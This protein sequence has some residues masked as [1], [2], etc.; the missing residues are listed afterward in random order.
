MR[1]RTISSSISLYFDANAQCSSFDLVKYWPQVEMKNGGGFSIFSDQLARRIFSC[2]LAST[3][4]YRLTTIL[5]A[6]F[7]ALHCGCNHSSHG[8]LKAY[9]DT[10]SGGLSFAFNFRPSGH[11]ASRHRL[12][13]WV[14]DSQ[15]CEC[16]RHVCDWWYCVPSWRLATSS[17]WEWEQRRDCS[18][19]LLRRGSYV[20]CDWWIKQRRTKC[21][22]PWRWH[23]WIDLLMCNISQGLRTD[24]EIG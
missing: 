24:M 18:Y 13:N 16:K 20:C 11:W 5:E 14:K 3:S 2:K 8:Q 10:Y 19:A 1:I 22:R 23:Y 7:F 12:F 9:F 4:S 6:L 21:Q 15:K 17:S